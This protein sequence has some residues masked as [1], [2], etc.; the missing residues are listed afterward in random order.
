[1]FGSK[2][3]VDPELYARVKSVAASAGYATAE[4]FV[5]HLLEKAVAD[6]E[7]AESEAAIR[8]RLQGLGYIE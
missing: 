4:E 6:A 3:K 5:V 7:E 8:Q 2:I 1:M